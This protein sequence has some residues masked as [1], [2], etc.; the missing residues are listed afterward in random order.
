MTAACGLQIVRASLFM[1]NEMKTFDE[2]NV[3]TASDGPGAKRQ[4]R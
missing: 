1:L 2:A 4:H 3:S